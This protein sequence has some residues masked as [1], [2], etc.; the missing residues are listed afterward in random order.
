M[1]QQIN[2]GDVV[3]V[4]YANNY[5]GEIQVVDLGG[6]PAIDAGPGIGLVDLGELLDGGWT[7]VSHTPATPVSPHL[8]DLAEELNVGLSQV[9]SSV[10]PEE[11]RQQVSIPLATELLSKGWGRV[12]GEG[13][14]A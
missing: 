3:T 1:Q 5:F 6:K 8:N 13:H 7:V 9:F 14:E 12:S 4:A 2:P 10:D 11:M